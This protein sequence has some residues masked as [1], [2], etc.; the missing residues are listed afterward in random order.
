MEMKNE[1]NGILEELLKE[2]QEAGIIRA[3]ACG[4][5]GNCA[6]A[7]EAEKAPEAGHEADKSQMENQADKQKQE[8]LDKHSV[9]AVTLLSLIHISEPTR[10]Y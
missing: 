4:T 8:V 1:K 6:A 10:P 9:P 5:G 2:M 3:V 7:Q